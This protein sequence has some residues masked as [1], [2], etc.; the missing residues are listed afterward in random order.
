MS[1]TKETINY[2]LTSG[3]DYLAAKG[4]ENPRLICE[5]LLARLL[6]CPG[7]ELYS[8]RDERL[9]PNRLEA[10]RRGLKRAAAG[11]PVQ[12]ITGRTGFM[13]HVF[14]TDR[15][16]LI[17]RPETEVL[18]NL[19]LDCT[20][21]WLAKSPAI[22]DVGTGSGCIILSLA[23][24]RPDGRYLAIDISEDALSLARE[25]AAELGLAGKVHFVNADLADVV[26]PESVDAVVANL[27]YIP[28]KVC[29]GLPPT[30]RDYD[31]RSALDGGP[32]G[33]DI[34]RNV[35]QDAAIIL[36]TGGRIFLEIGE[37]Q[38]AAVKQL[39][40]E[41]GFSQTTVTRDLNNRDRVVSA[42]LNL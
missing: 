11:E 19:V 8:R 25:N 41:S 3:T 17:P 32:D 18:V 6:G 40:E 15:R 39:L 28:S 36:K 26:D 9:S 21:L 16:A 20:D 14:K 31:P 35:I 38:A 4:I 30:V 29:D 13:N 33:L 22:I 42:T 5:T 1:E 12:H 37:E 10:M 27:P 24:A 23:D 34:I 2:I 7:L